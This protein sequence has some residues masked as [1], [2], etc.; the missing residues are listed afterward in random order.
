MAVRSPVLQL[1]AVLLGVTYVVGVALPRL[2]VP[3]NVLPGYEIT[4]VQHFG[5]NYSIGERGDAK[6]IF[7]VSDDGI[8][9]TRKKLTKRTDTVVVLVVDQVTDTNSWQEV[10][11]VHI[12][13]ST[14]ILKFKRDK[15]F[16]TIRE[17][18][19]I[20]AAVRTDDLFAVL[21][22]NQNQKTKIKYHL[23]GDYSSRFRLKLLHINGQNH[24]QILTR[25]VLDREETKEYRLTVKAETVCEVPDFVT[26]DVTVTVIDQNDNSPVFERDM[27]EVTIP[28]ITARNTVIFKVKANDVDEGRNA[29]LVYGLAAYNPN[30]MVIP[31]TG[32]VV[33][34]GLLD[35]GVFDL[36][37]LVRDQGDPA[38]IGLP[39]SLRVIVTSV[40]NTLRFEEVIKDVMSFTASDDDVLVRE[41]RD[42]LPDV[43]T[44]IRENVAVGAAVV[45]IDNIPSDPTRD[46]F[47]M[48][49]PTNPRFRLDTRTGQVTV[50]APLDRETNAVE[51]FTV[52]IT[53]EGGSQGDA[54]TRNVVITIQDVN[55][56]APEWSMPVFPYYA[57]VAVN[58]PSGASVYQLQSR[59]PDIGST[60]SY[61]LDSGGEG[62]FEVNPTTGVIRTRLQ[63]GQRYQEGKEYLLRV[64]A[65]DGTNYGPLATISIIAGRRP[66]Q[67]KKERYSVEVAENTAGYGLVR[68]E[69]IS[70]SKKTISYEFTNSQI[71]SGSTYFT[72]NSASGQITLTRALDYE[73][74]P[75]SYSLVVKAQESGTDGLSSTVIV[76]VTVIDRND[77]TP[78]F[79]QSLYSIRDLPEDTPTNHVIVR[80]LATDCDSGTNA[81]ISY[82]VDNAD[83]EI[84][85][86][87][88][89]RPKTQLDYETTN[90]L[91][92]VTATAT[93][94]GSP[95]K[96]GTATV[97]IRIKNQNDEAPRFSQNTYSY[98]V[99]ENAPADFQV[100]T[101]IATDPDG[102]GVQYSITAGN[103]DGNF[104]INRNTGV[105]TLTRNPT[106]DQA[107]YILNV[108]ATDDDQCCDRL[109]RRHS[110]QAIVV[111]GVN[112]VNNNRPI[113]PNCDTYEPKVAENLPDG[114]IVIQVSASDADVGINGQVRYNIVRRE[115]AAL[116]FRIDSY[117]GT[118]RTARRFDREEKRVYGISVSAVDQAPNPLIGICQLTIE[119]TDDNDNS[120]Q[121]EQRSYEYQLREDTAVDTRFLRVAAQDADSGT[122]AVITY[123]LSRTDFFDVD[124][125]TG[126]VYVKQALYISQDD[127]INLDVIATDMAGHI[128]GRTDRVP[129]TITISNVN[130]EPP[131]WESERYGPIY[132][133]EDAS[134]E[135]IIAT[136]KAT[137]VLSDPRVTYSLVQGQRPETNN[138]MRFKMM[139]NREDKSGE[140]RVFHQ[141]DYETTPRFDLRIR[142]VNVAQVPLASYATLEINLIDVNDNVPIFSLPNYAANVPEMSQPGTFVFQVSAEDADEGVNAQIKYSIIED[143]D[144][145]DWRHF[146]IDEN[147]GQITTTERFDR[148]RR[149]YYLIE[150]MSEDGA[151]SDRLHDPDNPNAPNTDSTAIHITISDINDNSPE[152]DDNQYVINIEEDKEVGFTISTVTAMDEDEGANSEI[153]YQITSGN[154]GGVFKVVPEVGRI[155]VAA[156]L[157]YE[158]LRD[159]TLTYVASDGLNENSTRIKV[160]IINVNDNPPEFTQKEYSATIWEEDDD[161]PVF[162][163][164]VTAYDPDL[165][166]D[167]D[168]NIVYSLQGQGAHEEF[169]IDPDNGNIYATEPL[170]REQQQVWVFSAVATDDFG[171]GL[172]GFA[173]VIVNLRDINDNA[174]MFPDEPY[175]GSVPE[176]SPASKY[177]LPKISYSFVMTMTAIDLD[178]PNE[179]D[180]AKL[181]YTI[182]ENVEEQNQELFAIDLNSADITTLVDFL[183]RERIPVYHI[184]VQAEDGGGLTGSASATI[185]LEDINDNAPKFTQDL[186]YTTMSEALP[187]GASVYTVSAIDMDIG[188][189]AQLTYAII[190]GNEGDHFYMYND[191]VTNEGIIRV[192]EMVDY[193]DPTQ[194]NFNLQLE[195]CDP[196]FCDTSAINIQVEDYNDNAPVFDPDYYEASEYENATIG[197]ILGTVTATDADQPGTNNSLF[198]YSIAPW[199]DPEN[200]F[201]VGPES[202]IVSVASELDRETV[203]YYDLLIQAI[204]IGPPS[205]TGNA[206]FHVTVLDINDNPPHFAEDYRPLV[207]E[208]TPPPEYVETISAVDPDGPDNGPPFTYW[209][210]NW[211]NI[212]DN[213]TFEQIGDVAEI[214]TKLMFDREEQKYHYMSIVMADVHGLS[215]TETLTIE[216][217]DMNDNPHQSGTK[218]I[219]VYNY[220]GEIPKVLLGKTSSGDKDTKGEMPESEIGTVYAPDPDDKDQKKYTIV[221]DDPEYFWVDENTGM[222]YILPG[223]PDGVYEFTVL[224]QDGI[225]PDQNSTVIVEVKEIPE[226]AVMSSGSIRVIKT[227]A[228]EFIAKPD[229]GE[230]MLELFRQALEIYLPAKYENIDVFSVIN[231]AD[232]PEPACD[233]RWSAHGSPYYPSDDMNMNVRLNI[234]EIED[235]VGITIGMVPVDLCLGESVCES[236]CTNIFRADV[237]P[238]LVDADH[239]TFISVTTQQEAACVCGAREAPRGLCE[240][241]P[242]Y[243]GGTCVDTP[244]GYVCQCGD[245]FEGTDC[246]D[247]KRSFSGQGY[248]WYDSLQTCEQTRTSFEFITE[249]LNGVLMYNGPMTELLP[250]EP[251][252]FMAVELVN[253]RPKLFINLGSGT[254]TLEIPNSPNLSDGMW[255]RVDVFRNA[256]TVEFM[257]D[258]CITAVVAETDSSTTIDTTSCKAEGTTPGDHE[259]LNTN[260]PLQLGGVIEDSDYLYPADFAYQS[261]DFDGCLKNFDQDSKIYDLGSP[262]R[263]LNSDQGCKQTDQHCYDDGLYLCGNGTCIGN[264]DDYYC[265]CYPGYHGDSCDAATPDYDFADESYITYVLADTVPLNDYTSEYHIMI[266]TREEE[267]LVW[268]IAD[269]NGYEFIRLELME[270]K[271]VVHFNL[272]DSGAGWYMYLSNYA[273]DNGVWHSIALERFGNHFVVKVDGGGGVREMESRLGA[274]HELVVDRESLVLGAQ[275]DVQLSVTMNFNGCMMDPRI[276]NVYLGMEND[277]DGTIATPSDGVTYGCYSEACENHDCPDPLVCFDLW[278]LPIC[279]CPLGEQ[280]VNDTYGNFTCIPIDECLSDPCLNGGECIDGVNG[281]TCICPI[282]FYGV[283]CENYEPQ[284]WYGRATL[285]LGAGMSILICLLLLLLLILILVIY[286]RRQEKDV[287]AHDYYD[288]DIR[289]NIIVYDDEGGGE[290]DQDIYDI[291]P[292]SKPVDTDSTSTGDRKPLEPVQEQPVRTMAVPPPQERPPEREIPRRRAPPPGDSPEVGDFVNDRLNDADKDPNTPPYDTLH[293]FDDE[294]GSSTAGSLSSLNTSS[295]SEPEQDYGYLRD[296]GPQFRKLADMYGG[297]E[298]D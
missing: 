250:Y 297:G 196:D 138:P 193:E 279:R 240:S 56:E 163:V 145:D 174:P 267:G 65:T 147:T 85:N 192:F 179:G 115:T 7:E 32:E 35:V 246:Q 215:G 238:T 29:A 241:S 79:E 57:T 33:T 19:A 185:E 261:I 84:N 43:Q 77:C 48:L 272:G 266:R 234:K 176:H 99:A 290:G 258:R 140:I 222:I 112:D 104:A 148:E 235:M 141:L 252:D 105:I 257:I 275:I 70:F 5:Q 260:M 178:D 13:D 169:E 191:R 287:I 91:Y 207:M 280:L 45:D 223:C 288:D 69:A 157:D 12:I 160:N 59:D 4:R 131:Q 75:R 62:L 155:E 183:D 139:T 269:T 236:S 83:F 259:F 146:N 206:T 195:V 117:D 49:T 270:G 67:F 129:L 209:V 167:D 239:S 80:V 177:F 213:F 121:F 162:V 78:R 283:H 189:N 23:L 286:K 53:R 25:E 198:Y 242:C 278:R 161:V 210:D 285:S 216:I 76:V 295:S 271:L 200:Q 298:S 123:S 39:S 282:G 15:Y 74:G 218:E 150:V 133:R 122:N 82:A 166:P 144:S 244:H 175:V 276:T 256:Q 37:L 292:L 202:G 98:F 151:P 27:Y 180:N 228:E 203:E 52:E 64:R 229:T 22:E 2:T 68:V 137:S 126:W 143:Q 268:H 90:S 17:N 101:V 220:K 165:D 170:D 273:L 168:Q 26:T 60:V 81:Q 100:A 130:N 219:F 113:F 274:F 11:N 72:I 194:Q 44:S 73:Q 142:A 96:T 36:T 1:L 281:Y 111:I 120:P 40:D 182:L 97:N 204:D 214:Y 208:N 245:G 14:K 205:L 118:I 293:L 171:N 88:E 106:L 289:E 251:E 28:E 110:S 94:H 211:N 42:V 217:D 135:D 248:A 38:Q 291:R 224:V 254:L 136:V 41:R 237:N 95:S 158:T 31:K 92:S 265:I 124:S 181:T 172:S 164:Q 116:D 6:N 247:L 249:S 8:V 187:V 232:S 227:T 93:D 134:T 149:S 109:G 233:V 30:F 253:G 186:Y 20:G 119:I 54:N 243:N 263:S 294:G 284:A 47:T 87:G 199:T 255:H 132:I 63:P 51:E 154:S 108:T 46:R 34:T 226:E 10:L 156:P 16:A 212:L 50:G 18:S 296:L 21:P 153:R 201:Y 102:D 9:T 225:H 197:T 107:S 103:G 55:D 230:S 173:D 71:T 128:D 66:P 231:V 89:I 262:S 61:N 184:L 86:L 125:T 3:N 277:T 188:I 190:G 152:F 221:G 58:A 264:W 159:Y 24:A 127:R 114:T